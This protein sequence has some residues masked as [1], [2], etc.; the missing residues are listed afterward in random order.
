M[1]VPGPSLAPSIS[2]PKEKG[3]SWVLLGRGREPPR[4]H[5]SREVGAPRLPEGG[6]EEVAVLLAS[7][8]KQSGVFPEWEREGTPRLDGRGERPRLGRG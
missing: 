6:G 3:G 5:G 2:A 4:A 7:H 8:G 1:C